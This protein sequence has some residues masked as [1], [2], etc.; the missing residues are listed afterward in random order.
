VVDPQ[1][2]IWLNLYAAYQDGFLWTD[3]GLSKQP[4]AYVQAMRLIS[5]QI[6]EIDKKKE[7]KNKGVSLSRRDLRRLR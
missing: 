3:G 1:D 4:Y 7:E 6:A 5:A 2:A